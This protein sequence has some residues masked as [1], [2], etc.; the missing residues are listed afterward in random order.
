FK[1][2]QDFILR[3]Y[4]DLP[5]PAKLD[6][7]PAGQR[8]GNISLAEYAHSLRTFDWQ[9]FLSHWAGDR[10]FDWLRTCVADL[11]DVV[12]I[13]SRTGV[14]DM[15]GI[16]AYQLADEERPITESF[17]H[18]VRCLSL[19]AN[20]SSALAQKLEQGPDFAPTEATLRYD[21]TRQLATFDACFLYDRNDSSAV[22][23]IGQRLEQ[24]AGL[25]I[26]RER[27]LA[28]GTHWEAQLEEALLNTNSIVVAISDAGVK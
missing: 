1:N 15:G 7:M 23:A 28:L 22:G 9:D 6:L 18:I 24:D 2:T 26:W 17:R 5:T 19:L 4:K 11:Y 21:P 20:D 13:D 3:V 12:L 14:T 10:F 25:R 8:E 27:S 16:C